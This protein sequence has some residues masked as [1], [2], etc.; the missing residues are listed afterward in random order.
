MGWFGK[1][2]DDQNNVPLS[3]C[4]PVIVNQTHQSVVLFLD[5]GVLYNKQVLAPGEAVAMPRS[6]NT[7]VPSVV[8]YKIH[9]VVGDEKSLPTRRQSMT[10]AFSTAVIPAAF[11]VGTLM[12]ASS[13][14]TSTALTRATASVVVKGMVID[15]AALAAGSVT[16][17]RAAY[18]ADRLIEKHP[19]NFA[20][21]SGMLMPGNRFVVIRG[22][23]E[24]PLTIT[25]IKEQKFRKIPIVGDVKAPMDT[26]V[27]KMNYYTPS[28]F[29]SASAKSGNINED[30]I[31]AI[32][33]KPEQAQAP[34]LTEASKKGTAPTTITTEEGLTEQEDEELM[35]AIA[36]SLKMEEERKQKEQEFNKQMKSQ[37]SPCLCFCG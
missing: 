3:Q 7:G 30:E 15:S 4:N 31:K 13:A 35:H 34:A 5:R 22:G 19:E 37:G 24:E 9:A 17:N 32:A 1:R 25:C 10:N 21:K 23:I 2:E 26:L 14:G 8:P 28:M 6:T 20:V 27:D 36:E 18:I 12:A 29:L 11:I 16:A 33:P